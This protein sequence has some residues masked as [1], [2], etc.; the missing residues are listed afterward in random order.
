MQVKFTYKCQ[1]ISQTKLSCYNDMFEFYF[2]MKSCI[3]QNIL[4]YSP[5]FCSF[6]WDICT[7]DSDLIC[8]VNQVGLILWDTCI[9]S[10]YSLLR[11]YQ[12]RNRKSATIAL[13]VCTQLSRVLMEQI[14]HFMVFLYV[15]G[16]LL[17]FPIEIVSVLIQNQLMD[18]YHQF[19]HHGSDT[20][21][22]SLN[23]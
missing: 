14:C 4:N 11:N 3:H 10:A 15:R 17:A 20:G 21:H 16:L 9:S 7:I 6:L 13:T 19:R 18:R 5:C 23:R 2:T 12:H 1:V 22:T 8:C